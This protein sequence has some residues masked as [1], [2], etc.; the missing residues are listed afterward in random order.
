[1]KAWDFKM[2]SK[3]EEIVE[4]LNSALGSVNGFVFNMAR[5]ENDSVKFNFRKRVLYPDQILHRNRI[6]VSGRVLKTDT[7][8]ETEVEI[9]F[10][11][12]LATTVTT[13]MLIGSGLFTLII[14]IGGNAS[15]YLPGGI[16]LALG[17]VFW[18]AL[19]GKFERDIQKYKTLISEILQFKIGFTRK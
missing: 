16:L 4:K 3:P 14:A 18:I 13:Y 12:H 9:S 17:I 15:A 19:R 1:M 2:K 7:E 6:I 5:D 8:N 11:Q 10:T